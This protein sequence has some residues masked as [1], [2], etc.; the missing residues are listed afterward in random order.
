MLIQNPLIIGERNST[1]AASDRL[2][3]GHHMRKTPNC[4]S[5]M[6]ALAAA[7]RARAR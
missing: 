4:V 5:G 3:G 2:C 6:G 7:L 1:K